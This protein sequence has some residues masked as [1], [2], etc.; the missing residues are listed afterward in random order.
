MRTSRSIHDYDIELLCTER[1]RLDTLC[2]YIEIATFGDYTFERLRVIPHRLLWYGILELSQGHKPTVWSKSSSSRETWQASA[3]KL[4]KK[5]C[6]HDYEVEKHPE[7]KS[8]K[9]VTGLLT[10]YSSRAYAI[11]DAIEFFAFISGHFTK[12]DGVVVA[13]IEHPRGLEVLAEGKTY[14]VAAKDVI[15]RKSNV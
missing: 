7:K 6:G 9:K 8:A 1:E 11:G 12:R 10:D 15:R 13:F 5:C 14:P 2:R 3:Q 4:A